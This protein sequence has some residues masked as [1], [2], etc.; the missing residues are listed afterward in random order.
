MELVTLDEAAGVA[1]VVLRRTARLN[2]LNT[3]MI[4]QLGQA[5]ADGAARNR[6]VVLRAEPG[7]KVFSAGH[8]L[9]DVPVHADPAAWDN[10]V[11]A[12]IAGIPEL[13]VP[14]VAA[15]E[16]TVWGAACNLV[17]ACD[18]IVAVRS[19]SFA[20]TPAKLGVPYF[21]AGVEIFARSLP[22]HVVKAM[23]FT[24]EP[25]SAE[26]AHGFGMVH[27]LA[28]DAVDLEQKVE[29]LTGRIAGLAPLTIRSVKAELAAVGREIA[30]ERAAL[31]QLRRAAWQSEDVQEGVLA[32]RQRRAP[33]FEGR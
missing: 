22:L 18:V 20:I 13:P 31:D 8:D 16:G 29:R 4:A 12:V 9:D 21:P 26:R 3:A 32:F 17:V 19:A 30:D 6:V 28:E 25:I 14:V 15:V 24:A 27:S 2:S 10:P 7:V 11:E 1:T 5:L 33:V 23:F